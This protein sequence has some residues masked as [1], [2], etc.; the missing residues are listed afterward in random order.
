M[1]VND[2]PADIKDEYE[3]LKRQ[4]RIPEKSRPEYYRE[5]GRYMEWKKMRGIATECNDEAVIGLYLEQKSKS[6]VPTT[7]F[8]IMSMLKSVIAVEHNTILN[9][10]NLNKILGK[11]TK[12]YIPKK[13]PIL[14][15]EQV[16][17]FLCQ[18]DD[19]YLVAKVITAIGMCGALRKCEMYALKFS[20][21]TVNS[22]TVAVVKVAPSKTNTRGVICYYIHWG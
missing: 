11:K 6:V 19:L 18:P 1:S 8:M 20:D 22:D 16:A 15:R 4:G 9:T 2:V 21:I 7:L 14:S 3:A 5:Y 17:H 12:N 13:A 10:D